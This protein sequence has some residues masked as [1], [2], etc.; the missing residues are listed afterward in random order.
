MPK[1]SSIHRLQIVFETFSVPPPYSHQYTFDIQFRKRDLWLEYSLQYTNRDELSQEE[2]WEEGFSPD[3]D[4]HW[5][6]ALPPVWSQTLSETWQ[7]TR[8]THKDQ[9]DQPLENG[10]MITAYLSEGQEVSGVP[11]QI[12]HWEYLLQE[13]TQ[14]VYEATQREH[15]LRIRYLKRSAQGEELQLTVIIR[16]AQRLL[17]VTR[18]QGKQSY[19]YYPDWIKTKPL[20]ST[21]YQLDYNSEK[22]L[23]KMPNHPGKYLD[24]GDS[25]WYLL[26][27]GVTNLSKVDRLEEF[28]KELYRLSAL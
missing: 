25:L 5:K 24:P 18:Q 12:E 22:A 1:N 14:A 26:G 2:I 17:E 13:L 27:E 19:Q 3:D 16:F 23:S 10:L 6:G 9:Y 21:L 28:K 8:L 20:L 4:F 15:P 7:Q 11:E